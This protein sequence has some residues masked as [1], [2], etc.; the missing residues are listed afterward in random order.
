[1]LLT[2]SLLAL[3]GAASLVSAQACSRETLIK[4]RDKFFKDGESK[5]ALDLPGAKIALN[6]KIVPLSQTPFGNLTGFSKLFVEAAD[7]EKCDIATF[8]VS[9]SQ[10]L[11]TRLRTTPEGT[12]TEV[13]F[14]QAVQGDQFFRPSGFPLTTPELWSSKAK[15]G[16]P[17][18]IP[19]SWTP[20]GG[21]PGKDVDKATCK[22][23]AGAP[24][25]L[26]RKE[27][28]FI[29][30]SYA[31]GLRGDPWGSCVIGHGSSCPRN[32]NGVTTTNNCSGPQT[33]S[34]GFLTRGR[35]WVADPENGVVLGG[36]YFD[37]GGKGPGGRGA[38]GAASSEAPGNPVAG[39]TVGASMLFLHEYFKV[40]AG[41]L[42]AIYAPMKNIPGKQASA[43]TFEGEKL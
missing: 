26:T 13:E 39:G 42:A 7:V 25:L 2:R 43:Q 6:N 10:V 32:E 15:P 31:D 36:F 23:G 5:T 1:M 34:F 20:I 21:I 40:E 27:L 35:R 19:P 4:V 37:Y 30:S 14:L 29:A 8:R 11:S 33:G 28:V 17:P 22:N 9:N 24:R 38:N 18:I 12:I 41:G 16:K 3:A